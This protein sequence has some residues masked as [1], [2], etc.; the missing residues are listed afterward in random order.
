M[1]RLDR[2]NLLLP[3]LSWHEIRFKFLGLKAE[4]C[5]QIS[6]K[7]GNLYERIPQLAMPSA[8]HRPKP[9]TNGAWFD[10]SISAFAVH[11]IQKRRPALTAVNVFGNHLR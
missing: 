9:I 7:C 2:L 5:V 4:N 6:T 11:Q 1:T 10:G 8:D 3:G